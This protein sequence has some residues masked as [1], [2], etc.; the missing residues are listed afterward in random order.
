MSKE[1]MENWNKFIAALRKYETKT[2][3]FRPDLS[4]IIQE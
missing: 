2:G 4:Y 3:L 1:G